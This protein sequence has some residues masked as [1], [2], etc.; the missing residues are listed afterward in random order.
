MEGSLS[1]GRVRVKTSLRYRQL[2]EKHVVP[3]LGRIRLSKLE[4]Q[5]VEQLLRAGHGAGVAAKTCNHIRAT[6]RAC[7]N[8]AIVEGLV[9]GNAAALARPQ[10]VPAAIT[11]ALLGHPSAS[12]TLEVYM[13]VAPTLARE[14]ADAMDRVLRGDGGQ[15]PEPSSQG[16]GG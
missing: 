12:S 1:A 2:L 10:K 14:A 7:L 5:Q 9:A 11:M 8:D 3:A 4:P 6:L 16:N 13:R 15:L